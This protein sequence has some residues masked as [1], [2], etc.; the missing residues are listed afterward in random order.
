MD[1]TG[2]VGGTMF[3][4]EHLTPNIWVVTDEVQKGPPLPARGVAVPQH[5]DSL[6]Q[7]QL[8]SSLFLGALG[9]LA[10]RWFPTWSIFVRSENVREATGLSGWPDREAG[11][12]A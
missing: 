12:G 6:A 7:C 5:S 2:Q 10:V 4:A 9:V 3:K 11:I 8:A 1:P